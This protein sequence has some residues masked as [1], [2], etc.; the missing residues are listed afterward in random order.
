MKSE[1]YYPAGS[2]KRANRTE[3]TFCLGTDFLPSLNDY[4]IW[5]QNYISAGYV[6]Q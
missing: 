6:P 2:L 3:A 5:I 4:H 1:V